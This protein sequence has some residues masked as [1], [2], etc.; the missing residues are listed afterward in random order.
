MT[1]TFLFPED[2]ITYW[3]TPDR[4]VRARIMLERNG[5]LALASVERDGPIEAVCA[6]INKAL[7]NWFERDRFTYMGYSSSNPGISQRGSDWVE[8][9]VRAGRVIATA[10]AEDHDVVRAVAV[11]YLAAVDNLV[12]ALQLLPISAT[13]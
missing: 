8:V 4:H 2:G 6:A 1:H 3:T 12:A 9:H 13:A 5:C 11:A 7:E 10:H